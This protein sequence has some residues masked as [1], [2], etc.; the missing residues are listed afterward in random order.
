MDGTLVNIVT[1][2]LNEDNY[3][4]RR[5]HKNH[6]LNVLVVC[7]SHHRVMYCNPHRPG[8]NHDS[9]VLANS[10]LNTALSN[11]NLPFPR[12]VFLGDTGY[13]NRDY[14]AIPLLGENLNPAQRAYNR[15]HKK[16]RCIVEQ[17]IGIAK[18]RFPI[19]QKS[20]YSPEFTA[21]I[22]KAC[23]ILHNL[24]LRHQPPLPHGPNR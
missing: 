20:Y 12:A 24:A 22:V 5:G 23:M 8:S 18:H 7:D 17:T 3:V 16:T 15:A 2:R 1:P 10:A 6:S 11:G 19:L 13:P 4:D 14:L 21:E 9:T